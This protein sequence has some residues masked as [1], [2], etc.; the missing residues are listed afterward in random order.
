MSVVQEP[1]LLGEIEQVPPLCIIIVQSF[2]RP[3]HIREI[4][5]SFGLEHP[6]LVQGT[7]F[8]EIMFLDD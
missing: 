7:P 8:C 3:S 6:Y 4:L 1:H 5:N 2:G